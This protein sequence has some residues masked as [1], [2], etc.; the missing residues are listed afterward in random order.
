[1]PKK[2]LTLTEAEWAQVFRLRCKSKQGQTLTHKERTLVEAAFESDQKRYSAMEPSV[3]DATVP[4]GSSVKWRL[5]WPE[6]DTVV[7]DTK[8]IDPSPCLPGTRAR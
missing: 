3:F 6:D 7:I 4:F 2:K 1:M 8:K 5:L